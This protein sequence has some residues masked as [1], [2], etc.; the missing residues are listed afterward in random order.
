MTRS[1]IFNSF[2]SSRYLSVFEIY[3]QSE[4]PVL[5]QIAHL[6]WIPYE[7]APDHFL[8][9]TLIC[10]VSYDDRIVF[11]VLDYRTNHSTCFSADVDMK[12]NLGFVRVFFVL[13]KTLKLDPNYLLGRHLRR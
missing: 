2:F 13:S 6:H 4:M 11:R 10:S 5:T 1:I 7:G 3:P 12:R 9:N 8:P